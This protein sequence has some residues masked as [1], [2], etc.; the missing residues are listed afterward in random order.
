MAGVFTPAFLFLSYPDLYQHDPAYVAQIF[1][2][3]FPLYN[4]P[5]HMNDIHDFFEACRNGNVEAVKNMASRQPA[6]VNARD[7]KGF[8]PL[9]IAVYNNQ[10]SVAAY[11]IE[12]GADIDAQDTAGNTALMGV[13]FKGYYE[14][15]EM[16]I[17]AGADVNMR[18]GNGAPALTFAA[19]FGQL[20]IAELL[21]QKGAFINIADTRGKTSYDHAVLQENEPMIALLERYNG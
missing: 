18:N 20:R 6:L 16:L 3:S 19:T 9:I 2:T 4:L 5:L 21:L 12:S 15:A 8:T 11:L 17:D 7:V 10:P 14:V 13:S 1:L